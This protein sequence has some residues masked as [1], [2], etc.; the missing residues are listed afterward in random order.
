MPKHTQAELNH[1][2]SDATLLGEVMRWKAGCT[3][4]I[5]QNV[6]PGRYQVFL[7]RLIPHE[8][9]DRL[10]NITDEFLG[11]LVGQFEPS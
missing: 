2:Q 3:E 8:I 9:F 4:L 11:S 6:Y 7:E 10:F 1:G 5:S